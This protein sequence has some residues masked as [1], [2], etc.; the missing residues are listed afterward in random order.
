MKKNEIF[1]II[2]DFCMITIGAI[3]AAFALGEFLI[4]NTILDGGINGISMMLSKISGISISIFIIILNIPFI[5][6]GFKSLGKSFLFKALYAML[7]FSFLLAVFERREGFT[8]D[9][10]LATVF[11]GLMLGCGVGLIIKQGGCLDGTETVAMII[12]KKTNFSVGQIVL[13]FN[14]VIYTIAGFLY[15]WDRALYS[16]L[17][18]F[19]TFKVIDIVSEGFEQAKAVLIITN[20][21]A[22]IAEDIYKRLGRTVTSFEGEGLINGKTM[23]LYSVITRLELSEFKE[24]VTKDD[25]KAFVTVT[26]VSEIIGRHVKKLPEESVKTK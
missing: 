16:L 12:S 24:I 13:M 14:V 8:N 17:T 19:I 7:A 21:S 25:R 6:I 5:L 26:D 10:I 2:M 15:G 22:E 20:Q 3:I 11:G 4:P 23:I 9:I 18:Y 1:K